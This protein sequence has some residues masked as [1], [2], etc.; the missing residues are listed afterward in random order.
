MLNLI[1]ITVNMH[2]SSI[3]VGVD[4]SKDHL[5][6]A[7][8]P[9]NQI[10]ALAND[11]A[12]IAELVEQMKLLQPQ[13]IVLEATGGLERPLVLTLAAA[14]LPVAVV[15]PRQVRDFAR[16]TGQL[17]K[18]DRIDA[19]VIAHFGE[20]IKPEVR[21]LSDDF[22]QQLD[23]LVTR[24]RQLLE[25]L[26]IERNRLSSTISP[27]RSN[28]KQHIDYLQKLLDELDKQ[29]DQMIT[30]S[31]IWKAKDDL[32]Q[33]TKGVGP[34][35]SRTLLAELPELGRLSR[36]QIAKLVGVAPLNNDSGKRSGRRSCWGGRASVRAALYMGALVATRWNPAIKEFYQ[37]L[38]A[39]GKPKKVALIAS[40]RKLLTIL[41]AMVKHST[42]WDANLVQPVKDH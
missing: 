20:A 24:R 36:Q 12:G 39:K 41:N 38:L 21:P 30:N 9:T 8:R 26:I 31:P 3:Y 40:M 32:L 6:L 16:A 25:M 28:V 27:L 29:L 19:A 2:K 23:A 10:S 33:S 35:L 34:V 7:C 1:E 14:G 15:N 5:D 17:A 13:L 42:P 11:P 18:T 22:T 37:R 4:V